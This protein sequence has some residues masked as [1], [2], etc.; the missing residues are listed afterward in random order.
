MELRDCRRRFP[1]TIGKSRVRDRNMV[2][3]LMSSSSPEV[4]LP[5]YFCATETDTS[6]PPLKEFQ[7]FGQHHNAK[8]IAASA[9]RGRRGSCDVSRQLCMGS[10]RGLC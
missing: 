7:P 6:E 9:E 5:R 2:G 10:N 3:R 8:V 1:P 4:I